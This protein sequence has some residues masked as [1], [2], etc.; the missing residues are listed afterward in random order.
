[1]SFWQSDLG[2]ITGKPEEAYAK[3][4]THIHDGTT[5]IARIESFE[6]KEYMGAAYLQIE[7]VLTEGDFAGQHVFHKLHV[8]DKDPN[9]RHRFLNL[10]KLIYEMFHV[11]PLDANPPSDQFLMT[12]VGKSAGIKIQLTQPN[13]D[14]GKQYNWVS[15]V[16]EAKGFEVKAGLPPRNAPE[17]AFSRNPKTTDYGDDGIPF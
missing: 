1:M 12:F 6:N 7:W 16:H 5:A 13:L 8:F 4:F 17:S 10:L 14:T 11:K 15:E 3:S 2:S 9:K